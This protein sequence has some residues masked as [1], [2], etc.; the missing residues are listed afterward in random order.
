MHLNVLRDIFKPG[1]G[2][3]RTDSL[4]GAEGRAVSE[5][6]AITLMMLVINIECWC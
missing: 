1:L 2:E 6:V 3:G 5:V 4:A